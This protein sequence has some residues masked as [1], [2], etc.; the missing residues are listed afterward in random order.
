MTNLI[1][2]ETEVHEEGGGEEEGRSEWEDGTASISKR[3]PTNRGM[4]G[5]TTVLISLAQTCFCFIR[6]FTRIKMQVLKAL[7]EA[8]PATL[9]E[10]N[11]LTIVMFCKHGK[12]RSVALGYLL[13]MGC[14][15]A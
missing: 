15:C 2:C 6:N 10:P 12:H 8:R 13:L 4:V 1:E 5:T 9:D 7:S 3:E 14:S 11:F